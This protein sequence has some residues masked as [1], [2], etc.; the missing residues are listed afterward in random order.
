MVFSDGWVLNRGAISQAH[1]MTVG[2]LCSSEANP[3]CLGIT[4][5]RLKPQLLSEDAAVPYFMEAR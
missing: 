4:G 2:W 1:E 3:S 5:M